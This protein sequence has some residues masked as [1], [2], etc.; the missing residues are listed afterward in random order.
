MQL[1]ERSLILLKE[2]M[3]MPGVKISDLQKKCNISRYQVN[4]SLGKIDD[5][6]KS[7]RMPNLQKGRQAGIFVDEAV[8]ETFPELVKETSK[9][10]DY[11]IS[12][13]ERRKLIVLMLLIREE[14]LS[15]FHLS[16]ALKVSRNTVLNDLKG[17]AS[18]VEE[19]RLSVTYTRKAGYFIEGNELE[20]RQI[21]IKLVH[22]MLQ[23]PNG[24]LWF[25]EILGLS[26]DEIQT[27]RGRLEKIEQ[28]LKIRFTD[29][30]LE[31]LPYTLALIIR[32]I[33]QQKMV[34]TYYQDLL[35]TEEYK[36]VDELLV[37]HNEFD[38]K[39][40]LFITLQ[41]LTSSVSSVENHE[42]AG[43]YGLI[44]AI[45]K[46]VN[47][48][49]KLAC[50]IF[51]DRDDLVNRLYLHLKPALYRIKYQLTVENL[52]LESVLE[53]HGELHHL[54]MKTLSP[55]EEVFGFGIPENESAYITMLLGSW[56]LRQGDEI[57][58][59]KMAIV[60]CPNGISV[61][62]LLYESLRGL[63]PEMLFLDHISLRDFEDYKLDYDL[64]FSTTF[65]KTDKKLFLVKPLLSNDE[66]YRLKVRVY[67]ELNGYNPLNIN[68]D[69]LINLI[70]QN[71]IIQDKSTLKRHL[72]DFFLEKQSNVMIPEQ[73]DFK[74]SL[75]EVIPENHILL[76]KK[77]TSWQEAVRMASAPLI[78][79]KAITPAYVD[80]MIN[81]IQKNEPY[82]VIAPK[83]A[84]PHAAP[85]DG[86]NR[87]SM[88]LLRL[89]EE[90]D[91]EGYPV[92]I[93][94]IIAAV[95]RKNHLK[96]LMQ[97]NDLLAEEAN[98]QQITEAECKRDILS[99]IEEYSK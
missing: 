93:F 32:R 5:W 10:N 47:N 92:R 99:V 3:I 88:S 96:A 11:V 12:D 34:E 21:I 20:K 52:L 64:V 81:M 49:E 4:Y 27:L 25:V 59:R 68:I 8:R 17:V 42:S 16:S 37:N 26:E 43:G 45:V 77:A 23:T 74:P 51:H 67:Q 95:D 69:D 84:I 18:I 53:E 94:I 55:L 30:K 62:K 63:F 82:I 80:A 38:E 73:G 14:P 40:L 44:D 13:I 76:G 79:S 35:N 66:K 33:R 28:R 56:L 65:I 97:L 7:N 15:L 36:A 86:V 85:E 70:E 87:I 1:D 83:V 29:E 19:S 61:S 46:M 75:S 54:V 57:S 2:I 90:V 91:L 98:I 39:E 58:T 89:E 71:T 6:L 22:Q 24:K 48:F 50:V 72:K 31:E 9:P 60:V 78:E 41:L